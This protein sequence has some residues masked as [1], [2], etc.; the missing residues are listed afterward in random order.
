MITSG[1]GPLTTTQVAALTTS[2]IAALAPVTMADISLGG[3]NGIPISNGLVF[4]PATGG[5]TVNILKK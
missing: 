2:Q 3:G 1:V 5:Q 4:V